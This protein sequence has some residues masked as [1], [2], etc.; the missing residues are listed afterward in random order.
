MISNNGNMSLGFSIV[1][2][3]YRVPSAT[4]MEVFPTFTQRTLL[5][6]GVLI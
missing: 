6:F 1:F 5:Y 2:L 4:D 3:S